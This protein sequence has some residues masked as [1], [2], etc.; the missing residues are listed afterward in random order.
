MAKKFI[1][2]TQ[3]GNFATGAISPLIERIEDLEENPVTGYDDLTKSEVSEILNRAG[4]NAQNNASE[5]LFYTASEIDA[6]LADIVSNIGSGSGSGGG[7]SS[8]Q[9]NYSTTERTV[10]TWIDGSTLYQKTLTGTTINSTEGTI[11]TGLTGISYIELV[12]FQVSNGTYRKNLLD[13][14]SIKADG[15]D[16]YMLADSD[17]LFKN[18]TFYATVLYTKSSGGS[19]E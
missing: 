1:D 17:S 16:I 12:D 2:V 8:P 14:V 15:T 10:G 18:K 11:P 13:S 9:L 7:S 5:G 3:L 19:G 6:M 4:L